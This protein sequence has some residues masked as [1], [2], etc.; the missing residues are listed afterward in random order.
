MAIVTGVCWSFKLE[1]LNGTH[2]MSTDTLMVALLDQNANANPATLTAYSAGVE[3]VGSGYPPGGY[4]IVLSG[5]PAVTA[6]GIAEVRYATLVTGIITITYGG[7]LIYNATRANRAVEIIQRPTPVTVTVGPLALQ[8]P[9]AS[10]ALV[11]I[12]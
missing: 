12:V 9:A 8:F 1:V 7:L 5:A 4:P 6:G 2:N 10:P 3:A 11:S